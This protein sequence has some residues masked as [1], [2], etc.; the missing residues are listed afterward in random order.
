MSDSGV[1]AVLEAIGGLKKGVEGVEKGLERADN[2]LLRIESKMNG[3]MEVHWDAIQKE[4]EARREDIGTL[5][6]HVTQEK[7]IILDKLTTIEKDHTGH[8]AQATDIQNR[9]SKLERWVKLA[10]IV[11]TIAALLSA[12]VSI[13][14][15]LHAAKVVADAIQAIQ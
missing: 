6:T 2:S 10:A 12:G 11:G 14:Q 1:N 4:K 13:E 8:I 15:I 7:T 5:K 9:V 3:K